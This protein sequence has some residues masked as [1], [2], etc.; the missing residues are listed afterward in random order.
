MAM[1]ANVEFWNKKWARTIKQLPIGGEYKYNLR[2]Y[3]YN[4]VMDNIP[5][6]S[7]VFDYA[8]GLGII[9]YPLKNRKRC[10]VSGCDLSEVAI[11][12]IKREMP[13]A[14]FRVSSEIFG[15]FYDFILALHILEHFEK[16]IEWMRNAFKFTNSIIVVIPSSFSKAGEHKNMQWSSLDEFEKIFED[17][18]HKRVDIGKYP[19]KLHPAFKPPAFIFEKLS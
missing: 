13:D 17:F 3:Q 10:T 9:D 16:P 15:G 5:E 11:S 19:P 14:D 2:Q 12:Y 1:S 8:C 4:I 6:G 7:N 18:S